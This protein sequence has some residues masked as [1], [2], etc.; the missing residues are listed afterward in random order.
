M[1]RIKNSKTTK[2]KEK[3]EVVVTGRNPNCTLCGLHKTSRARAEDGDYKKLVCLWGTGKQSA[4]I[5]FVGEAPG[6]DEILQ[7]QCFIGK[8]G[9]LF[10]RYLKRAEIDRKN[11]NIYITNSAKCRPEGNRTPRPAELRACAPYLD[12]EIATVKPKVI[13]ILGAVALKRVLGAEGITKL[14]GKPMWSEKYKVWC[15]PTWHPSF[16]LRNNEPFQET[17]QFVKDLKFIKK[18]AETGDTGQLGTKVNIIGS[19]DKWLLFVE[20]LASQKVISVDTETDGDYIDGKI[21]SVQFCWKSGEAHVLPLYKTPGFNSIWSKE[22]ETK[23]WSDLKYFLEKDQFKKVGQN[24][25]YEYQFFSLYGITLRGVIFD[26]MLG[27][28]LLDENRKG[29]YGLDE[30]ALKFT[31]MGD[32][33]QELYQVMGLSGSKDVDEHT[34]I[35][36]P[37]NSL[38]KYGAKDADATFRGF[39]SIFPRVKGEDLLFLLQKLMIPL[40]FVLAEMEMTGVKVDVEYFK[41]LAI[42]YEE[43]VATVKKELEEFPA[44]KV[45]EKRQG[46]P[47]NFGSPLQMRVLFY[48]ILNLPFVKYTKNKNKKN[49]SEKTWSTDKEVL[50]KL[51]EKHDMPRVLQDHRKLSKFLSTYI[52]PMPGLAAKDGRLHTS[53][54]QHITVTGRLASRKPNLQNIPKKDWE[55][56]RQI[57]HGLVATPGYKFLAADYGQ[58]EFRLEISES[59]DPQGKEDFEKKRDIHKTVAS[60]AFTISYEEVTKELREIAKTINYSVI[61]GKSAEN[62]AKETGL[63]VDQV[64]QV[65]AVIFGRYTRMK[66]HMESQV[67]KGA[68]IG[69]VTNWIGRRRR[70]REGFKAQN[71]AVRAEAARQAVNAPI[72]G[73]AHEIMTVGTLRVNKRFKELGLKSRLIM[74]THDEII[75]E[76]WE[77][78]LE[79]VANIVKTEMERPIPRINVPMVA[80]ISTGYRL[81]EMEKLDMEKINAN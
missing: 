33:S 11:S 40:S 80:D 46:K 42:E 9:Q 13:G 2:N 74:T 20:K 37:F 29:R 48:E 5:M 44:I 47:I 7:E 64:N 34:M 56:A 17:E 15:V 27:W 23:I 76:Y 75:T 26:T 24:I 1:P 28:Y 51:A 77:P 21:L 35:K 38:C 81:S 41:K 43:R 14:R 66:P 65:F 50:E 70:L 12:Y 31:D 79:I 53:Y 22:Q 36:A 78:E 30:L 73:G 45:L 72:Q 67:R 4:D 8:A 55:M 61:Y 10:D 25:K 58:I 18:I 69:Y 63:T 19:W 6:A 68:T 32:Y 54:S 62:L 49:K 3:K 60:A 59:N 52:K 71:E 16:L 39:C 57:R